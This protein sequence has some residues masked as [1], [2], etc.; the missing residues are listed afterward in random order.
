ME[1]CYFAK[2]APTVEIRDGLVFIRPH[3]A[4]CEIA[5]SP[6][7]L[8]RFVARANK[9]LDE[10]YERRPAKVVPIKARR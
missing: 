5:V 4:H 10:I 9:A 8:S 7:V 1:H 6:A 3:G 2:R